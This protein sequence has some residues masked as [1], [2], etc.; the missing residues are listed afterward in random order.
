MSLLCA[1]FNA[2]F[3][4]MVDICP[5]EQVFDWSL[6]MLFCGLD[7]I[8]WNQA[9]RQAG[10]FKATVPCNHSISIS[11]SYMFHFSSIYLYS[12][13][14][15]LHFSSSLINFL[16][17]SKSFLPCNFLMLNRCFSFSFRLKQ[18]IYDVCLDNISP[19][20]TGRVL[21]LLSLGDSGVLQ[22][23]L[24]PSFIRFYGD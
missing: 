1:G 12:F 2:L 23:N 11:L 10:S 9:G 17:S 4:D 22:N 13:L 5:S 14:F 20:L 8:D 16:L 24:L 15:I 18:L 6:E 19:E 3:I 21:W 7:S